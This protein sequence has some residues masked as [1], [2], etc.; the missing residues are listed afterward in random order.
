M[1]HLPKVCSIAALLSLSTLG[2]A[3]LPPAVNATLSEASPPSDA[4]AAISSSGPGTTTLPLAGSSALVE[5]APDANFADLNATGSPV[6]RPIPSASP[7]SVSM[8]RAMDFNSTVIYQV[9]LTAFAGVGNLVAPA[10]TDISGSAQTS[11]DPIF[12][13]DPGFLIDNTGFSLDFSANANA[14]P[15]NAN[16]VPES[17]DWGMIAGAL[18]IFF[19]GIRFCRGSQRP[20]SS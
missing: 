1:N 13:V 14:G 5:L 4:G 15:Q 19:G 12:T 17:S 16:R 20:S 2:F 3:Q 6:S 7:S 11:I 8:D 18:A 9:N 10:A